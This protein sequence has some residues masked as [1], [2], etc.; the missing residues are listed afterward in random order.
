MPADA[1]NMTD[2]VI[3][4]LKKNSGRRV[5]ESEESESYV[6]PPVDRSKR[7]MELIDEEQKRPLTAR[8][9]IRIHDEDQDLLGFVIRESERLGQDSLSS[10]GKVL[11]DAMESSGFT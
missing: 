11:Q 9:R 10:A 8:I 5:T 2:A 4:Q 7:R 1:A 3:L 6:R